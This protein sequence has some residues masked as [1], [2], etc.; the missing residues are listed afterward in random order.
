MMLAPSDVA[1]LARKVLFWEIAE[2]A[3][4][5]MVGIGCL[6]E[7]IAEYTNWPAG[8]TQEQK[9][10]LGRGSLILLIIGIGAGLVSLMQTNGLSGEVIGSLGDKAEESGAKA[11]LALGTSDK[12]VATSE[13]ALSQSSKAEGEAS[14]A[15][16]LA[17]NA[18]RDVKVLGSDLI[19]LQGQARYLSAKL[20]DAN[21][22]ADE[23][24]KARLTLEAQ[25][26]NVEVCKAS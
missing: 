7:Y 26:I 24:L 11:T 21:R 20:T 18:R 19:S 10:R 16:V 13:H 6:G 23:E 5:A 8:W 9:H 12:A 15:S 22:K 4:E 25:L 2:Y 1:S 14:S 17:Q 3:S